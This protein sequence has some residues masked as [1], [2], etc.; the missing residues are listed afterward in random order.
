M[1]DELII[2]T[3]IPEFEDGAIVKEEME[4]AIDLVVPLVVDIG[5][6]SWFDAKS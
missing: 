4:K 2:D 3:Y 5:E 6:V 1:H